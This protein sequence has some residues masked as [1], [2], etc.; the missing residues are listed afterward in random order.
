MSTISHVYLWQRYCEISR[1]SR[2][3]THDDASTGNIGRQVARDYESCQVSKDRAVEKVVFSL[4]EKKIIWQTRAASRKSQVE[5]VGV[6][7]YFRAQPLL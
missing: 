6:Y 1:N 5:Q 2:Y 7:Q 4:F 3:E